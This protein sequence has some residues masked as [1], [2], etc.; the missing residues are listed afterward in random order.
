M[1]SVTT[2][3]KARSGVQAGFDPE[4][5][6]E[7]VVRELR[8]ERIRQAQD[9]E[10]WI[11]G[12]KK[13]LVGEIRDLTQ[14][15]ARVFGSI[16]MNYEMDQ[17]DLLFYCPTTKEAAADRDKLMRLVVPEPLQQDILHHYH[18]YESAGWSSR[19]RSHL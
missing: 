14:E 11:S 17:S 9:E 12:L 18:T 13:Y 7:E 19:N 16:A 15:D 1:S 6:R 5:L 2:R 3:S 4:P 10:S 8:L